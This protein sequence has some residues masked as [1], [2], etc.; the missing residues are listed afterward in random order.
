[1]FLHQFFFLSNLF[2]SLG[3]M[4]ALNFEEIVHTVTKLTSFKNSHEATETFL[5]WYVE[6]KYRP[7]MK[8]GLNVFLFLL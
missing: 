6:M 5:N 7:R 4:S 3:H 2:N 8:I 1:M